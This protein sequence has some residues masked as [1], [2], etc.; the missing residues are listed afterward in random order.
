MLRKHVNTSLVSRLKL[1]IVA[2]CHVGFQLI[3]AFFFPFFLAVNQICAAERESRRGTA[4]H[5]NLAS[6]DSY[7]LLLLDYII[8]IVL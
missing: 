2:G 6:T 4:R 8:D 3:S 1:F 7:I 5:L